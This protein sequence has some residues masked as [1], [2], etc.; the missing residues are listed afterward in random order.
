[1]II[2]DGEGVLK[3]LY[4]TFGDGIWM[5]KKALIITYGLVKRCW[6][7]LVCFECW[8]VL[9][10]FVKKFPSS[11]PFCSHIGGKDSAVGAALSVK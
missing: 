3:I 2:A 9:A 11:G 10:T 1:M 4:K 8:N 7:E 6:E 5:H